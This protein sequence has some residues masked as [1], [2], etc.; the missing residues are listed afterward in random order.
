MKKGYRLAKD[1]S[2]KRLGEETGR[3]QGVSLAASLAACPRIDV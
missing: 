1:F 3:F 2:R